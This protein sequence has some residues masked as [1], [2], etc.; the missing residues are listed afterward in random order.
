[1]T[2]LSVVS[3]FVVVGQVPLSSY[4]LTW[5]GKVVDAKSEM[6]ASKVVGLGFAVNAWRSPLQDAECYNIEG[7]GPFNLQVAWIKAVRAN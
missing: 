2:F 6:N 5:R 7:E 3:S 4:R 1:M